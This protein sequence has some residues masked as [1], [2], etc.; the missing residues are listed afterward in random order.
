MLLA[1]FTCARSFESLLVLLHVH[2]FPK[3]KALVVT[4]QAVYYP[5]LACGDL[6]MA[7][8]HLRC[9]APADPEC[10]GSARIQRPR[11]RSRVHVALLHLNAGKV[12]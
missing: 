10:S 1:R 3:A 8:N 5:E 4:A 12:L 9:V 6:R 11:E 2:A 7:R